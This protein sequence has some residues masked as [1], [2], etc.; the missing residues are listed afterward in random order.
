MNCNCCKLKQINTKAIDKSYLVFKMTFAAA[1]FDMV[2]FSDKT[3]SCECY[4]TKHS[5]Q[6]VECQMQ[7]LTED[8]CLKAT[9]WRFWPIKKNV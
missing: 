4:E 2:I 9:E 6:I 1:E 7:S 5:D 3:D 8:K